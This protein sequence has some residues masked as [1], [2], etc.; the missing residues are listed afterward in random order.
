MTLYHFICF[1]PIVDKIHS[2]QE[3]LVHKFEVDHGVQVRWTPDMEEYLEAQKIA[4]A[5]KLQRLK[6]K[7]LH[8]V[9][10]RVFYL[11]TLVH[12]AGKSLQ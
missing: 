3:S 4:T 8:C 6:Q 2:R 1:N 12:H 11:N 9:K 5:G 7:M 10:E